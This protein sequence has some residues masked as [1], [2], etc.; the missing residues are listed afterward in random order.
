SLTIFCAQPPNLPPWSLMDEDFADSCQLVRP[1]RPP[2]RF[3][4]IGSRIRS[5]LPSDPA[6]RSRPCASLSFTSIRLERRLTLRKLSNMPGTHEKTGPARPEPDPFR[7]CRVVES[8]DVL[9]NLSS[10][11]A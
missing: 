6:S 3:L 9:L 11:R 10:N 5:T 1:R 8:T 2:I 4:S 7:A